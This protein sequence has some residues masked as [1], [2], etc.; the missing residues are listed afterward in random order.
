MNKDNLINTEKIFSVTMTE[1]E[2]RLFSE[3]LE[4]REYVRLSTVKR[5]V[6]RLVSPTSSQVAASKRLERKRLKDPFLM[7]EELRWRT[8]GGSPFG[9]VTMPINYL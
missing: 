8:E 4:Q 5:K 2:L 7:S 3:F 1:E 9:G 6:R